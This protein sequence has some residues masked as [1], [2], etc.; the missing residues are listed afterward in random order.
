M[1][2]VLGYDQ[3]CLILMTDAEDPVFIDIKNDVAAI[4]GLV[5]DLDINAGH[6]IR[7]DIGFYALLRLL[8]SQLKRIHRITRIRR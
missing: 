1:S 5:I 7:D 3:D 2:R 6:S 4:I 8:L